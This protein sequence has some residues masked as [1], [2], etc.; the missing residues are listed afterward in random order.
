MAII[1]RGVTPRVLRA[2]AT[3]STVGNS[4][5]VT[6]EPLCSVTSVVVWDVT[7][8][9]PVWLK[10]LGWD[11][12]WDEDMLMVMLPQATAQL[13]IFTSAV[14][15][16]VPVRSFRMTRAGASGVISIS[17]RAAMKSMGL[18]FAAS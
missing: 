2:A 17:S 12:S 13:E 14:A 15:T 18:L 10:G 16:M 9:W 8:V 6:R 11:T 3:F 1:S 4:G 7:W 5:R